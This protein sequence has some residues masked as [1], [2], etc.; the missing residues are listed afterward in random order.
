MKSWHPNQWDYSQI[1]RIPRLGC[2]A[3]QDADGEIENSGKST[4]KIR[5]PNFCYIQVIVFDL[6]YI[7]VA[8]VGTQQVPYHEKIVNTLF[9]SNRSSG[10]GFQKCFSRNFQFHRR[11]PIDHRNSFN[12]EFNPKLEKSLFNRYNFSKGFSEFLSF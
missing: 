4:F 3:G 11:D 2:K 8:A 12:F 10:F 9:I 5:I 6:S 7:P 1:V